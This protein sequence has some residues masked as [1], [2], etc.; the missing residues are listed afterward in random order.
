MFIFREKP[1]GG[2]QLQRYEHLATVVRDRTNL[3]WILENTTVHLQ[4]EIIE[5]A[6][7]SLR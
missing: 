6:N 1:S 7:D 4:E 5:L 2:E 3:P